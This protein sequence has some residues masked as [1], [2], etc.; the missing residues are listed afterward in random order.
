MNFIK[1][2]FASILGFWIAFILFILIVF[3]IAVAVTIGENEEITNNTI[4]ELNFNGSIKDYVS[5]EESTFG[6]MLDISE[7][8]GFNQ[9]MQTIKRAKH[10]SKIK[11]ISIN[12]IPFDIGWAQ[13]TELR[14]ELQSFK[15]SGKK[16]WAC[17]CCG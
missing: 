14:S 13:L 10:D 6:M 4:L 3:G 7:E 5:T 16:V 11:A 15:E 8:I 9:I 12:D 2:V 17:F 1:T